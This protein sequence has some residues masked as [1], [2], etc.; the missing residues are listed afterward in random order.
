MEQTSREETAPVP[1]KV[2]GRPGVGLV[3]AYQ[4]G[5]KTAR[6]VQES[7]ADAVRAQ[8]VPERLGGESLKYYARIEIVV[9]LI[10]VIIFVSSF[11][12]GLG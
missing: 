12:T 10:D 11:I 9:T 4:D 7:V 5:R 8:D 6:V 3:V 1:E 2:V